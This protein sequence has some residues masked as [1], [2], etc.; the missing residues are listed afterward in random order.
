MTLAGL[1]VRT[2][3]GKAGPQAG[4]PNMEAR[5]TS[6]LGMAQ[7]GHAALGQTG[8]GKHI[9]SLAWLG[10]PSNGLLLSGG[11]D[12]KVLLWDLSRLC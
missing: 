5:G 7:T 9:V 4:S 1:R 3:P 2:P 12:G 11:A 10:E 8:H 6:D